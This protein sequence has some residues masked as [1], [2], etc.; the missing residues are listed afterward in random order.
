MSFVPFDEI[1]KA[2]DAV[3]NLLLGILDKA[4]LTLGN[5]NK[6][7]FSSAMIFLTSNLGATEMAKLCGPK[8]GFA[9]PQNPDVPDSKLSRAGIEAARKKFTPEFMNRLDKIV[10]FKSLG[11]R[12]L[13]QIVNLELERVQQRINAASASQSFFI[14]PTDAAKDFLLAEGTDERYGARPLKRAIER[15]LVQPLSN[16]IATGKIHSGDT[17]SI[18]HK[19]GRADLSFMRGELKPLPAFEARNDNSV[20]AERPLEAASGLSVP[21]RAATP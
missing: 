17:I 20:N 9:P 5:N 6:V 16:L 10:V 8:I 2:S 11:E 4:T 18:H 21:A 12:E 1:E 19:P 13:R 3:W 15:L 14:S 7:D